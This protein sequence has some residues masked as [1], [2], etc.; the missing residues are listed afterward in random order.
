[1]IRKVALKERLVDGDVLQRDETFAV[2]ELEHSVDQQKRI[3][4]RQQIDESAM[5]FRRAVHAGQ[6]FFDGPR[7]L[8]ASMILSVRSADEAP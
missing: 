6:C 3:S 8:Y 1:M 5:A 7:A 2:D 4:M